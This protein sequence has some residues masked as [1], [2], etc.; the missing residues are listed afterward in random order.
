MR[1]PDF[2]TRPGDSLGSLLLMPLSA[3]YRKAG[4]RRLASTTPF[5]ASVPVICIGNLTLGGAGKTPVA[6]SLSRRLTA[7][8][9]HPQI[10]SRGYGGREKG[11]LR[12]DPERHSAADVGDEPLLLARAAPTWVSVDRPAGARAAMTAGADLLIMDDGFQNP[13]LHKDLSLIVVD[14]GS[15]F[16]NGRVFPAGPL[17]EMPADGLARAQGVVL[18]GGDSRGI[19]EQV[20]PLPL[21]HGHYRPREPMDELDGLSVVAFAGIGRPDKFFDTLRDLG[22][23]IVESRAFADHHPYKDSEIHDLCDLAER[24][25]AVMMTTAKDHVR[26][27]PTWRSRVQVVEVD[28]SWENQ[29]ALDDWLTTGLGDQLP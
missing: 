20:T 28:L 12:V 16:G 7:L 5:K 23:R 18:I 25:G 19:A 2:W 1:P 29:S 8:G 24:E 11:P 10:L 26:L 15:G 6:L 4:Q 17:R 14:G 22:C 13:S 27:S 9:Y 3:L 21:F